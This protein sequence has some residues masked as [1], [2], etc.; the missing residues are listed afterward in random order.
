[1]P[2]ATGMFVPR[3]VTGA[4]A[5]SAAAVSAPATGP[6]SN[7]ASTTTP[8]LLAMMRSTNPLRGP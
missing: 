5:G 7:A 1:M 2:G 3:I 4:A 8:A 6:S